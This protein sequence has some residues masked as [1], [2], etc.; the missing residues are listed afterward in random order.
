MRV[1]FCSYDGALGGPG[2]SQTLPYV[3][4]LA[5]SGHELALLSFERD[6]WLDDPA[7]VAAAEAELGAVPW[8][9]LRWR[10]R[11][12]LDLLQG[13]RALRRAVR[14]HRADLVHARGYVPAFLAD[15][16]RR[17]FLFDMRGFWPDERADG[18]LWARES[19]GY[20]RWK[21]LE[22]RLLRRASGVVVLTE[23]AREELRRGSMAPEEQRIDVIPCC[24]DLDRFR[25][26]PS[27]SSEP[28]RYVILG[29]TG[30]W[31]LTAETF[32]L[33]AHA[34]ARDPTAVLE[35]LTGDPHEPIRAELSARGVP[36]HRFVVESVPHEQ[37]P[38]RLSGARAAIVLIRPVWSKRASSPTKLAELLGCGVP[39][40]MNP[41]VGDADHYLAPGRVGASVE[42]F[43]PADY[44]AALVRLDRLWSGGR[45]R[46][47]RDCRALA[48]RELALP[49]AVARYRTAYAAAE[50]RIR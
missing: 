35:V 27:S 2:R 10:R 40:L 41:G 49:T 18:G 19:R 43:T 21:R 23:A 42:G 50:S 33:A 4:E 11:P 15:L 30:T 34:L 26:D 39:L 24:A 13:V 20:R 1:V 25:P 8:T 17:P 5:R 31:Y 48:E 44:D 38:G 9:R 32:D 7:R 47:V 16:L 45:E 12:V 28:P 29:S 46:V 3:R 14:D 22:A 37:V 6:E 36:D